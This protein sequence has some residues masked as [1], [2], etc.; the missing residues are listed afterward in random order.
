M[1]L[2]LKRIIHPYECVK[3]HITGEIIAYGDYYYEDDDDGLIVDFNY[4]HDMKQEKKIREA[5]YEI[6][7]A[8]DLQEYEQRMRQ[9]EREFLMAT[10]FD[11]NVK[12]NNMDTSGGVMPLSRGGR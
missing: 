7:R 12:A 10:L 9:A 1:A 2:E 3:C 4:Y 6:E 8:L 5:E 11:R